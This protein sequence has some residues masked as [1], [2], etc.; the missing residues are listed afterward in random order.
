MTFINE[1]SAKP[2]LLLNSGGL[3]GSLLGGPSLPPVS[4][5]THGV[6]NIKDNQQLVD[7]HSQLIGEFVEDSTGIRVPAGVNLPLDLLSN[8]F[9]IGKGPGGIQ[10]LES[11]QQI[12][13]LKKCIIFEVDQSADLIGVGHQKTGLAQAPI[14]VNAPI[15]LIDQN[16]QIA[17]GSGG[18]ENMKTNMQKV[19][20]AGKLIGAQNSESDLIQAVAVD[21]SGKLIGSDNSKF[22]L[23]QAAVQASAPIKALTQNIQ[24]AEGPGG[25]NNTR[26]N[27]QKVDQSAD[28]LGSDNQ[29][30][31]GVQ[32][33]IAA[34]A[35]LIDQSSSIQG[36]G[37]RETNLLQGA[38]GVRAPINALTQ[39]VQTI[40]GS[41]GD[42]SN[43]KVNQQK[44][45]Y[46]LLYKE[47]DQSSMLK[48]KDLKKSSLLKLGALV[49]APIDLLTGNKQIIT[50]EEGEGE[51][52]GI[53]NSILG[54]ERGGIKNLKANIQNADFSDTLEGSD[55]R[56][57]DG[58]LVAPQGLLGITGLTKNV[59][60]TS[61][62]GIE[63][64]QL[65]AQ[66]RKLS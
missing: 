44:V 64:V 33:P 37:N 5:V 21:Q 58:L 38:V 60:K 62:G 26:S 19:H 18:I 54:S 28:L 10:N 30:L 40:E 41:E 39:N 59:Q 8:N 57:T 35:P 3:L 12:C 45:V 6:I 34:S 31:S 29:K 32:L 66:K 14:Q 15:K 24:I 16:T 43:I 2:Q 9:Q 22:N 11:N 56:K 51:K 52:E 48:G 25:I 7:Q 63:N 49:G 13:K 36:A 47:T 61:G 23:A 17:E 46:V 53:L 20:Q 42:I 55:I 50:G 27:T 65:N 4:D 1:V